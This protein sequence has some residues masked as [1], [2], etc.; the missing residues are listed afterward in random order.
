MIVVIHFEESGYW[1][2]VVVGGTTMF[3]HQGISI[4]NGDNVC[5]SCKFIKD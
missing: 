5:V 2:S 4:R 3:Y 1:R